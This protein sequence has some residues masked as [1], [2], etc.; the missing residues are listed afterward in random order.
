MKLTYYELV[1]RLGVPFVER[2]LAG[3]TG[4][5][6]DCWPCGCLRLFKM[7]LDAMSVEFVP[8]AEH[9]SDLEGRVVL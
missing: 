8:C 4:V 2:H 5:R 6:S 3:T 7:R 1:E 9:K